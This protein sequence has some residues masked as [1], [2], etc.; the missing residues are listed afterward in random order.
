MVYD[1]KKYHYR[2]SMEGKKVYYTFDPQPMYLIKKIV[3]YRQ[4]TRSEY[5]GIKSKFGGLEN[6]FRTMEK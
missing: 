5:I 6:I 4:P 1:G 2:G 3:G